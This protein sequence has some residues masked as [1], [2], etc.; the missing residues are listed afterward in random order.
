MG[1]CLGNK[2]I[3][4]HK[5]MPSHDSLDDQWHKSSSSQV[6][7]TSSVLATFI[8]LCSFMNGHD[9]KLKNAYVIFLKKIRYWWKE[10]LFQERHQFHS[11]VCGMKVFELERKVVW[12]NLTTI[13]LRTL[14]KLEADFEEARGPEYPARRVGF[15]FRLHGFLSSFPDSLG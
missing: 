7:V 8:L 15:C 3:K 5:D 9:N 12:L 2:Y 11:L 4:C 10:P 14:G 13:A 6:I 1:T